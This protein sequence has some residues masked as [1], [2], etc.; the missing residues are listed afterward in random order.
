MATYSVKPQPLLTG[1]RLILFRFYLC[2]L[3]RIRYGFDSW[4]NR[5]HSPFLLNILGH[6]NIRVT[7]CVPHNVR[8]CVIAQPLAGMHGAEIP[9]TPL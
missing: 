6:V 9:K 7:Q 3:S 8:P 5:I 4:G 2:I 1:F